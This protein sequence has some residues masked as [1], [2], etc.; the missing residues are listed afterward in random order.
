MKYEL[1]QPDE[2]RCR[3]RVTEARFPATKCRRRML[4][5]APDEKSSAKGTRLDG[6]AQSRAR[7]V[8]FEEPQRASIDGRILHGS[9]QHPLLRLAI[10]CGEAR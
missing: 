10:R 4:Q 8:R 3:L 9:A 1:E 5:P 2:T 6:I 7:T